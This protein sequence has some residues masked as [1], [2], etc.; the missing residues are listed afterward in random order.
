MSR[1]EL[2]SSIIGFET[3]KMFIGMHVKKKL[4]GDENNPRV[5]RATVTN[6]HLTLAWAEK[7]FPV[8][9]NLLGLVEPEI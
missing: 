3:T 6:F 2:I 9:N 1:L 7:N 8:L 5:S 4:D